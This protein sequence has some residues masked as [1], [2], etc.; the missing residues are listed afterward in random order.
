MLSTLSQIQIE[1]VAVSG[2][3]QKSNI[4]RTQLL[5]WPVETAIKLNVQKGYCSDLTPRGF[6]QA[7][8]SQANYSNVFSN[9]GLGLGK[10]C[11]KMRCSDGEA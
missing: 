8:L 1:P 5:S 10:Q 11:C 2:T 7:E 9:I 4:W 3:F 6:K